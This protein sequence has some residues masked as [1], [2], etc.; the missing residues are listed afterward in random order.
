MK[1]F[2]VS[3]E[4]GKNIYFHF[5]KPNNW[6]FIFCPSSNYYFNYVI[7]PNKMKLLDNPDVV[8]YDIP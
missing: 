7:K 5:D 6:I 8:F 4:A 1:I 2:K 3:L